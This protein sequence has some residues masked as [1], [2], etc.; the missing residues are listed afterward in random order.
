VALL[1]D[2]SSSL[3]ERTLPMVLYAHGTCVKPVNLF[4]TEHVITCGPT[5]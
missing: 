4:T 2:A 3:F 5:G 1:I